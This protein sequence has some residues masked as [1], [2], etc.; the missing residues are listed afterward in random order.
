[1]YSKT[2][3]YEIS[4]PAIYKGEYRVS[5]HISGSEGDLDPTLTIWREE[6]FTFGQYSSNHIIASSDKRSWGSNYCAEADA[7]V[8]EVWDS[9][10]DDIIAKAI[11][12]DELSRIDTRIAAKQSQVADKAVR[13]ANAEA[14]VLRQAEGKTELDAELAI[15]V[16]QKDGLQN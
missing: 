8:A 3:R 6:K 4:V 12:N 10:I 13:L 11:L 16:A 7:I 14:E 9:Q 5:I 2:Q 15:L 1:M